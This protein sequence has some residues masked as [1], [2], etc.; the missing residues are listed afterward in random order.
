MVAIEDGAAGLNMLVREKLNSSAL[1]FGRRALVL[2]DIV[3]RRSIRALRAT[4]VAGGALSP[5][6][7]EISKQGSGVRTILIP[8]IC[9]LIPA[10]AYVG[11]A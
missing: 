7:S 9:Y 5:G 4:E 10:D 3:K 1:G 6:I 11:K 2:S 8:E